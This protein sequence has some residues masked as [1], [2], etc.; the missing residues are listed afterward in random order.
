LF[1]HNIT[2]KI[3]KDA[4]LIKRW[5]IG[6]SCITMLIMGVFGCSTTD[7]NLNQS[8]ISEEIVGQRTEFDADRAFLDVEY[9]LDLGPR[10]PGSEA[11]HRIVDWMQKQLSLAGWETELQELNFGGKQVKN[12]VG[13]YGQGKPWIIIG[14]HYDSRL[15]AD[16]DPI[17]AN[18]TKPVPGANDGASGVAVL[19][20]L[21]R[22]I[23]T[24]IR[25]QNGEI[26]LVFF[27]AEDSGNIPGW[28]W[29]M[30]SQ[31]FVSELNDLPDCAVI[32]DMIGDAN[33]NVYKES[34]SDQELT[35]EI[36]NQAQLLGYEN[37]LI[38]ENGRP[39]LDDHISFLQ[40][41]VPAITIID[42]DYPYWHTTE[43]TLD[44]ISGQSLKVIGDTLLEW[45]KIKY[46]T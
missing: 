19:L 27:D 22:I 10:L 34:Y 35:D 8:S 21:A 5:M 12:V 23:P 2:Q 14:A 11:H 44:K 28:E 41:G 1:I 40:A 17:P 37:Y 9:Q 24:H 42:I 39:I 30:G 46:Q 18:R 13:K 20:E 26:W 38:P 6:L 3:N 31:A 33:L 15:L 29:I 16:G 4:W 32:V 7:L 45:L 36:W 43:D 25:E